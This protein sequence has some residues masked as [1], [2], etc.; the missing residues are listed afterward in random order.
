[1]GQVYS[2]ETEVAKVIPVPELVNI[3]ILYSGTVILEKHWNGTST[4]LITN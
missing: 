2:Y 3:V 1:M 4:L